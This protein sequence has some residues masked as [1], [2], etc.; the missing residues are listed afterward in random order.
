MIPEQ[1]VKITSKES[2]PKRRKDFKP[3]IIS[4]KCTKCNICI[5]VCPENCISKLKSGLPSIDYST[6]TGCL[7]CVRECPYGAIGEEKWSS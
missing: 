3:S 5:A 7:I 2:M 6:C 4:Q 1:L